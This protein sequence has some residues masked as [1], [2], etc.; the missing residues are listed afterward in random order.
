MQSH[1]FVLMNHITHHPSKSKELFMQIILYRN[2][3]EHQYLQ[4]KTP[5][6]KA[7]LERYYWKGK[8]K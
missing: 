7:Q 8:S 5:T 2:S 6:E 3:K 4:D 1:H